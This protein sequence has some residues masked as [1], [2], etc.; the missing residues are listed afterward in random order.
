MSCTGETTM[1]RLECQ[2]WM[3]LAQ[4][5]LG[6]GNHTTSAR[7][8]ILSRMVERAIERLPRHWDTIQYGNARKR[9]QAMVYLLDFAKQESVSAAEKQP[10]LWMFIDEC[11]R[12]GADLPSEND[13]SSP[14]DFEALRAKVHA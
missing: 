2:V 4:G 9:L 12:L 6:G 1:N 5:C 8:H 3:T 11:V 13:E 10:C 7:M 14:D